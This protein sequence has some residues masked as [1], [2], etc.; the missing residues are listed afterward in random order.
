MTTRNGLGRMATS[1]ERFWS[2]VDQSGDCW[3]WKAGCYSSGYG[4]F[5][6]GS[7]RDGSRRH[8]SAHRFAYEE[9]HGPIAKGKELHHKCS[10]RACVNPSHLELVTR[11]EH[12]K[13]SP[14]HFDVGAANR[15]KTHCVNGHPLSG[16][17][18]GIQMRDG[19]PKRFCWICH[20]RS[21]HRPANAV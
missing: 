6:I 9:R 8:I 13:C 1:S 4:E 11:L 7:K 10:N 21:M 20:N 14:A 16:D 18:L 17:N 15:A 5:R 12:I 3:L 19:K 2:K